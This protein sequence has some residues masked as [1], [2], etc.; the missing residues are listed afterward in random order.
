MFLVDMLLE[1]LLGEVDSIAG[2]AAPEVVHHCT[3][4]NFGQ[5]L[6]VSSFL[7]PRYS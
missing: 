6:Q 7:L 4:Q 2:L 3:H 1:G 5:S